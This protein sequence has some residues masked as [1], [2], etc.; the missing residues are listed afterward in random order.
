MT[1]DHD[2]TDRDE[3]DLVGEARRYRELFEEAPVM[4]LITEVRNGIAL[5]TACNRLFLDT[6]GYSQAEVVGRPLTSFYSE[7]SQR[8][9]LLGG[10]QRA[11]RG[12]FNDEEREFIAA[13]GRRVTTLLRAVPDY[14]SEGRLCGTRAMYID[15]TRQKRAEE[16]L[17]YRIEFETLMTSIS[18]QFVGLP[19]SEFDQHVHES[20]RRVGEFVDCAR[21]QL[22]LL[23]DDG[24]R[25]S[26]SHEWRRAGIASRKNEL[27][28]IDRARYPWFKR[29]VDLGETFVV[30]DLDQL[31]AEAHAERAIFEAEGI[32]SMLVTPV[33][34][35]G[36]VIGYL[37][38]VARN[39]SLADSDDEKRTLVRFVAELI[40]TALE[41]RR[42]TELEKA[43]EAAEAASEAKSLFLANMSHEI[44]TPM[45][46]ILG[47]S[48]LML[49]AALT[50]T[51]QSHLQILKSS[52]EGLLR[53]I[54]D[55]LDFSKIEAGKMTLD[56]DTFD[57]HTLVDAA[58][59][60]LSPRAA[61][62][63]LSLEVDV[64]S[65][66]PQRLV[67]DVNRLRQVLINLVS[68]A[69]K[70]T[71]RGGIEVRVTH[72]S[73]DTSGVRIRFTVQDSGIGIPPAV[74]D[75]LFEPFT[76]ADNSTSRRYGGTGLGLAICQRLV[77]LMQGDLGFESHLGHGS[78]FWFSVPLLPAQRQV[79]RGVVAER[80]DHQLYDGTP[81]NY[82]LLLAEDNQVNQ[83]VALG[84]I[85]ALGYRADAVD[86]GLEVL[87][88]IDQ[89]PYDLVLMDCQMP[90]LD[91]YETTRRL[92]EAGWTLPVVAVTAHAMKGD[93]ERCL[94]A[95]MNEYIAKPFRREELAE[96][97]RQWLPETPS[98][99]VAGASAPDRASEST[100][101]A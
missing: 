78:T 94:A 58:I 23:S 9:L 24:A 39:R 70:F 54:D 32:G 101:E 20:L 28:E 60:P 11:L 10:Y 27:R 92:R 18:S 47:M 45:N 71:D 16:S 38:F 52:A 72:E 63:G 30:A 3:P 88:V 19:D 36:T 56:T 87:R 7:Q 68:N 35:R 5:I 1:T 97:L 100:D 77:E 79:P 80:T 44:R 49:D 15:V 41:R 57:L 55:I 66:F 73:L 26:C 34:L 98:A 42:A 29:H 74:Q 75:Q 17:R 33:A 85:E 76:Q 69:I 6:L 8:E 90:E 99:E 62:R 4:Y 67:G 89:A 53:L 50:E 14:D 37:S 22:F 40:T 13:D 86:N 12:E 43:K 93:R 83:I 51:Q 31:P 65:E 84:Q 48:D 59:Q 82:R 61:A 25:E 91:G 21:A 95:G 46:A 96:I 81:E 2:T 64:T